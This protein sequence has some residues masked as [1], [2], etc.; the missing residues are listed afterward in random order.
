M[1]DIRNVSLQFSCI[2]ICDD[3]ANTDDE[4]AIAIRNMQLAANAERARIGELESRIASLTDEKESLVEENAAMADRIA[5][6]EA[7][8]AS[9]TKKEEGCDSGDGG[10]DGDGGDN[11]VLPLLPIPEWRVRHIINRISSGERI[12]VYN[13]MFI[14]MYSKD[15]RFL[16]A[17]KFRERV[18]KAF[19]QMCILYA[20]ENDIPTEEHNIPTDFETVKKNLN[21]LAPL[22][23]RS[24]IREMFKVN[25]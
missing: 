17:D 11:G 7:R 9:K 15:N 5:E 10:G 4:L 23:E 6:L 24:F 14:D 2:K 16:R 1:A 19:K 22:I 3:M 20:V 25:E 8:D 21:N 18:I 13:F 12:T